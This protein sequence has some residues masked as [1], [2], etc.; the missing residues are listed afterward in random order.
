MDKQPHV[1]LIHILD[2]IGRIKSYTDG[3][4]EDEFL[5]HPMAQDAVIRN[6]E[7]IGEA[8]KQLDDNFRKSH[9]GNHSQY[10]R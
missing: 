5:N 8:T 2:C 6:F 3:M 10:G 4:S 9:R 7:V 1:Y